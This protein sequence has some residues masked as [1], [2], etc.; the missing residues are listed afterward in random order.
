MVTVPIEWPTGWAVPVPNLEPGVWHYFKQTQSL[1][2]DWVSYTGPCEEQPDH[3]EY[4]CPGCSE[5]AQQA[6]AS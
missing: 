5:A 1:C 4:V 6:T 3:E 2:G